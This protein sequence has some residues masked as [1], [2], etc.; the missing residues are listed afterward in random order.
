MSASFNEIDG[1]VFINPE[2]LSQDDFK[3]PSQAPSRGAI[4]AELPPVNST[5]AKAKPADKEHP[6]HLVPQRCVVRHPV[7]DHNVSAV[8][9]VQP[10]AKGAPRSGPHDAAAQASSAAAA[11][12]STSN[13]SFASAASSSAH[14]VLQPGQ[15]APELQQHRGSSLSGDFLSL[16][17]QSHTLSSRLAAQHPRPRPRPAAVR[18]AARPA[19]VRPAAPEP[20]PT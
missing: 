1:S 13:S 6:D 2:G 18:P 4:P 9:R 19:T 14:E 12:R 7:S 17:R 3:L 5:P 8:P 11:G 16:R 20:T 15:A 10:A